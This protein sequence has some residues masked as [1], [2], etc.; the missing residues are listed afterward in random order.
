MVETA[1]AKN[2]ALHFPVDYVIGNKF[3]ADAETKVV[4]DD[5]GIPDGWMGLDCGPESNKES[6]A[7]ILKAKTI[8][9][10]GPAGVFE[11]DAFAAGTKAA[12]E[13][14]IEATE[15]VRTLVFFFRKTNP[16]MSFGRCSWRLT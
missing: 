16:I 5:D 2:V 1:K 9:W 10:N 4:T 8:L 14:V 11:F 12:L 3:A 15:N 6:K 7:A 13:A